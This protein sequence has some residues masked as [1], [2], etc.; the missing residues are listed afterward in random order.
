MAAIVKWS[1]PLGSTWLPAL[2]MLWMAPF[3]SDAV[4]V[5]VRTGASETLKL[6]EPFESVPETG[7]LAAGSLELTVTLSPAGTGFHQVSVEYTVTGK[8]LPADWLAGDPVT[9]AMLL[10]RGFWPGTTIWTRAKMPGW[11]VN[12]SL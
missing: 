10:G 12:G 6:R 3:P 1:A 8:L 7:V 11:T 4:R 5:W 9:P 2:V